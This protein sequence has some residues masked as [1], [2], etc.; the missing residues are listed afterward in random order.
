MPRSSP[1][2]KTSSTPAVLPQRRYPQYDYF[3]SSK[4]QFD[5]WS[6]ELVNSLCCGMTNLIKVTSTLCI[7]SPEGKRR[8]ISTQQQRWYFLFLVPPLRIDATSR[9]VFPL[10]RTLGMSSCWKVIIR[11]SKPLFNRSCGMKFW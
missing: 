2:R 1:F 6:A 10:R 5:P 11:L 4:D 8:L 7:S 9:S 3:F